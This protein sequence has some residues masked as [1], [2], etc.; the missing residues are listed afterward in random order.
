M[1]REIGSAASGLGLTAGT[2]PPGIQAGIRPKVMFGP[3]RDHCRVLAA[4][5]GTSFTISDGTLNF[6][7]LDAAQTSSQ[8][9]VVLN[10]QSGLIGIPRQTIDGVEATCLLNPQIRANSYVQIATNLITAAQ[11]D[12]VGTGT[13]GGNL[14]RTGSN[15]SVAGLSPTGTY[16]VVFVDHTGDTRGDPWYSTVSCFADDGGAKMS[17]AGLTAVP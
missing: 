6:A 13:N 16:R 1:V 15:Q 7:A 9:A 3:I 11:V 8:Q 4:S 10:P 14:T 2:P 12:P 5:T 17:Q